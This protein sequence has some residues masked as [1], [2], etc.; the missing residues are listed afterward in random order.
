ME[1]PIAP[2]LTQTLSIVAVLGILDFG[3][4]VVVLHFVPTGYNP[5]TQAVSD[6][7]VANY[8]GWMNAAFLAFGI[9]VVAL[10]IVLLRIAPP[11]GL[12]RAGA[13]LLAAAGVC[14]FAV[15]FFRTDLEGS[16]VTTTGTV[17]TSLSGIAFFALIFGTFILS[18]RFRRVDLLRPY[19]RS[20]LALSIAIAVVFLTVLPVSTVLGYL[21]VGER[22]FI[23]TFYAW[24][25]LNSARALRLARGASVATP[26]RTSE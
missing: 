14:L 2:T 24:L 16:P 23:A 6:Y 19:Y 22:A 15:G 3:I 1:K 4:T 17:H 12:G 25:L 13:L 5:L 18:R 11:P 26:P 8:A 10:G 9:G 7:G 20:S 21:G